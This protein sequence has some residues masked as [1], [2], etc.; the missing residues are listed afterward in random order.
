MSISRK[1]R[2][3]STP[4]VL[5]ADEFGRLL[6]RSTWNNGVRDVDTIGVST[7]TFKYVSIPAL[8]RSIM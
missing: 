8:R 4:S 3:K 1:T 5:A 6:S 2:N 7:V